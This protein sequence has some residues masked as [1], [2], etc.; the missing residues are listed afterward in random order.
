M[1]SKKNNSIVEKYREKFD[2]AEKEI[3]TLVS[4]KGF[5]NNESANISEK[6]VDHAL[7]NQ[8]PKTKETKENNQSV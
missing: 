4:G 6:E 3:N 8:L 1:Q 7:A 5:P 2:L